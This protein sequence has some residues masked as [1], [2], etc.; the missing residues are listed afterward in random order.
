MS[1]NGLRDRVIELTNITNEDLRALYSKATALLFPSLREGFGWPI[2]EA[3]ACGCPV[4]TSDRVP[5]TEVG[6][7]A[8]I[9]LDPTD[10][11]PA[12]RL[13]LP[14][15]WTVFRNFGRLAWKMSRG[16]ARLQ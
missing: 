7:D 4:F 14:I 1:L 15:L 13:L 8:A 3:Q 9:Y 10:P 6:G 5:M 2:I 11:R 16:S 12:P